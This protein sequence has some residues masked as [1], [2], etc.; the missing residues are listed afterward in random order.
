MQKTKTGNIIFEALT[1]LTGA[2]L[3]GFLWR[4]RGETG[5]GSSWGLLN[6]GF[7]FT[8]FIILAK[9]ER[10]KL[11][12]GWLALTSLSF[13]MTVP[14]WGTLLSQ[15]TGVLSE[16]DSVYVSVWSAVVL[17]LSLGFGLATIFGIMLGR[18]YSDKQWKIK[19]FIILIAV[20]Y[21]TDIIA[22]A[23]VS[24]LILGAIQPEAVDL[25]E[26][27]L[28]AADMEPEVYK[29]YLQHF[30]N[31]SW[32]KKF[33][34]GRNYFSSIQV[35][36][37]VFRSA[38]TLLATRFIIKDKVAAK[39][40]TVVSASFAFAITVADLFFYF[41]NGDYHMQGE[42]PFPSF[43]YPWGC[44]EFFT[45]FIAGAIITA[46]ILKLKN[47][48]NV[49]ETTFSFI[50]DKVQNVFCILLGFAAM[51]GISIVRP[52][53]ERFDDS[54]YQITATVIAVIAAVIF[55]AVLTVKFRNASMT[56][57][58]Y[59]LLPFYII[60]IL[61][62]YMFVGI[63]EK[64]NYTEVLLLQHFLCIVSAAVTLAW[65]IANKKMTK[66]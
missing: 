58:S 27:G 59:I 52:V 56:Q 36:A 2:F 8:L 19:D 14:A 35:I 22:K 28:A 38:A 53:L 61:A 24:H 10:K 30:D 60:Y 6:A 44:W 5:W 63:P 12:M 17:M 47:T 40:G 29:T 51:N 37:S 3:L 13:M 55:V 41:G 34:G 33:T 66:S 25:F 43:I 49:P 26:K 15:I 4:V 48:D 39:T 32:G 64:Q 45:G 31:V 9:G 54:P 62:V 18:G 11:D 1:V 57:L 50:P 23:T 46:Y 7:V 65:T 16:E 20:F 42:S 21:I